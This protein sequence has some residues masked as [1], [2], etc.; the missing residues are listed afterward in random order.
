MTTRSPGRRLLRVAMWLATS[1]AMSLVFLFAMHRPSLAVVF[2][3]RQPPE[4]TYDGQGPYFMSVVKDDIDWSG[5][6]L[7]LGRNYF[8]YVGRDAGTPSYGH[9]IKFSFHPAATDPDDLQAFLRA[10]DVQWS[11]EGV[12]LTLAS[13]HS[14]FVPKKMFI[15]GR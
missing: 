7:R 12:R 9:M 4:L 11:A 5:F 13:G 8:I 14:L 1:L 10:A 3:W 15:G 2:Q 6:P